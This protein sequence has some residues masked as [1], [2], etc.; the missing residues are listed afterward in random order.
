M[1]CILDR[2][3]IPSKKPIVCA[4]DPDHLH[5]NA[6]MAL[7]NS[8]LTGIRLPH[9][10]VEEEGLSS[11]WVSIEILR[12]LVEVQE[13]DELLLAPR[14]NNFTVNPTHFNKMRVYPAKALFSGRVAASIRV[15]NKSG[16]YQERY[17]IDEAVPETT[18]WFLDW[19][20]KLHYVLSSRHSSNSISRYDLQKYEEIRSFLKRSSKQL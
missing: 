15:L 1:P 19:M 3:K 7:V 14:V 8:S 13:E 17:G 18:A 16:V 9:W 5:K 4:A 12:M 11:D 6:R 2:E 10:L 20:R